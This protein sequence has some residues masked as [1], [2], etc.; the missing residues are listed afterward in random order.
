MFRALLRMRTR[1]RT[2][3]VKR[4]LYA[5]LYAICVLIKNIFPLCLSVDRCPPVPSLIHATTNSS[6]AEQGFA[7]SYACD[8]GYSSDNSHVVISCT[9]DL[10]WT[11][12]DGICKGTVNHFA[13]FIINGTSHGLVL[14]L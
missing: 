9:T 11:A 5:N 3:I 10:E 1:T 4:N 6:I 13:S 2:N 14:S 8:Q 12:A 7:V